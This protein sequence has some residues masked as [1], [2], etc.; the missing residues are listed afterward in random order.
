V[1]IEAILGTVLECAA[2]VAMPVP[3]LASVRALARLRA[4]HAGLSA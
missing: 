1:E 3:T 4:R 2:A